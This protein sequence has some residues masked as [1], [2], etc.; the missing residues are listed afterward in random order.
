MCQEIF[1]LYI[2]ML[3]LCYIKLEIKYVIMEVIEKI[4]DIRDKKSFQQYFKT[5]KLAFN[6]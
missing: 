2:K 6:L 1:K 4:T 3:I 5:I